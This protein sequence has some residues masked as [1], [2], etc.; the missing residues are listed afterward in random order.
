MDTSKYTPFHE[1]SDGFRAEAS[2]VADFGRK[3]LN[4]MISEAEELLALLRNSRDKLDEARYSSEFEDGAQALHNASGYV[5]VAVR[6]LCENQVAAAE[7]TGKLSILDTA[8]RGIAERLADGTRRQ[9]MA[10]CG[11]ALQEA[12]Q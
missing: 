11:Q 12:Q 3:C 10:E 7:A 9:L 6:R 1:L 4:N 2:D 5:R 8:F